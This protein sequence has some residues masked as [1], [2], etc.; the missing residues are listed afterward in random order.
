MHPFFFR[1]F[2]LFMELFMGLSPKKKKKMTWSE[3][4]VAMTNQGH[5]TVYICEFDT[6]CISKETSIN[7]HSNTNSA[8][9][10]IYFL[11]LKDFDMAHKRMTIEYEIRKYAYQQMKLVR[12]LRC[13]RGLLSECS[14][15]SSDVKWR[16]IA[17]L[18][19]LCLSAHQ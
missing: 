1:V 10:S 16:T 9:N 14:D 12:C 8:S 6:K 3:K 15:K 2:F 7:F 17:N 19:L 13:H 4:I 18:A 11:N 5:Y